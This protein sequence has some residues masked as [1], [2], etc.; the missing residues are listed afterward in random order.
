MEP[1][2]PAL[3]QFVCARQALSKRLHR[4]RAHAW[5]P[6]QRAEPREEPT[7]A[8]GAGRKVSAQRSR[9]S[10]PKPVPL[11]ETI[12]EPGASTGVPNA[13]ALKDTAESKRFSE[14]H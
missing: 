11:D 14:K 8:G 13:R 5:V 6:I 2:P 4:D 3:Y 7:D 9:G 12:A 10:P 1:E